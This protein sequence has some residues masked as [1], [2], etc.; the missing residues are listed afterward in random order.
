LGSEDV[1]ETE[2]RREP[3][4]ELGPGENKV[5][6]FFVNPPEDIPTGEK[7]IFIITAEIFGELIGGIEVEVVKK[8][9]TELTC[10]L[11][12]KS[13]MVGESVTISGTLKP[14]LAGKKVILTIIEPNGEISQQFIST[15]SNGK[16]SINITPS[17]SGT[18]K[19]SST[20]REDD[21]RIGSSSTEVTLNVE[22]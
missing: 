9:K 13:V 2:I 17:K 11:T 15:G 6:T 19:V 12:P 1:W 21:K 3:P 16:Y 10:S 22:K 4:Q 14:A 7:Q 18:W 20:W 5:A 8:Q